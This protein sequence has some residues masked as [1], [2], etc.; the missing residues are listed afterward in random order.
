MIILPRPDF[1]ILL[2]DTNGSYA[3]PT[4][5]EQMSTY[6]GK[7][8]Y[9]YTFLAGNDYLGETLLSVEFQQKISVNWMCFLLKFMLWKRISMYPETQVP[10]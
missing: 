10:G 9:P 7:G 2:G 6:G 1:I 8:D 4:Y 3:I 5:T